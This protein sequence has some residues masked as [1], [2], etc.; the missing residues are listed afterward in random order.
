MSG[1]YIKGMQMP[2]R[3]IDCDFLHEDRNYYGDV[4]SQNC[5]ITNKELALHKK[6]RRPDCPLIDVPDHGR[7]GD[8]DALAKALRDEALQHTIIGDLNRMTFGVG[9]ALCR[10]SCAPTVIPADKVFVREES[11]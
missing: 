10:I 9:D 1:V 4:I 11:E 6:E 5:F 2:E 8:F 7:L 3:C